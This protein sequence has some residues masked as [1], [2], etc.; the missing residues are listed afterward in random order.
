MPSVLLRRPLPRCP[1]LVSLSLVSSNLMRC[2]QSMSSAGSSLP[3]IFQS[4][5]NHHRFHLT[6]RLRYSSQQ[7]SHRVIREDQQRCSELL[8]VIWESLGLVTGFLK[9]ETIV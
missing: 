1:G 6:Y 9:H 7:V 4:V 2:E 8:T 3:L 5:Y